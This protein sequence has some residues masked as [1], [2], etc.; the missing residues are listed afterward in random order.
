MYFKLILKSRNPWNSNLVRKIRKN[1]YFSARTKLEVDDNDT[2]ANGSDTNSIDD[3]N[4]NSAKH[5]AKDGNEVI[6]RVKSGM[7]CYLL[8]DPYK[9]SKIRGAARGTVCTVPDI[10]SPNAFLGS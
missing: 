4:H 8:M 1:D 6:Y 2:I 7:I 5:A 10:F 9:V 3:S